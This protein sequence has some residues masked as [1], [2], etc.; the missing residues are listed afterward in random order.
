MIKYNLQ[1][2]GGNGSGGP[3]L[4]NG[5]GGNVNVKDEMDV[6][7]YRHNKNNENFVDA[8][9]GGVRTIQNDFPDVMNTVNTVTAAE[10]GGADK[11]NTL[12]AYG[13]GGLMM[14]RNFTNVQKMNAVYD[15]S[16]KTGYHPS[17]G[18]KSGTEAVAI[19]EMGHA[20]TDHIKSKVGA[21]NLQDA[22][23]KIVNDAYKASNGKG[24]TK[25]FA[26]KISKYAQ[27]SYAECVAEAVADWYCNGKKAS[28]SSK[29]IMAQLKK[30]K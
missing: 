29:A 8:I 27:D 1:F 21:K 22:S 15:Q 7:S 11:L 20:L 18:N 24:G 26:G 16:V 28:T 25:A 2:F 3:S 5:G 14:N 9:N 4:G 13:S 10:F 30:Y 23:K 12:G 19:H 6:W 17:R